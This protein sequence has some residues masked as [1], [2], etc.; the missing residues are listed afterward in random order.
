MKWFT[1]SWWRYLL[2]KPSDETSTLRAAICRARGHP[3]GVWWYSDGS[4]PN[5]HCVNCEDD[6]G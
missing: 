1:K 5:M 3:C 6:L 4:E 2:A